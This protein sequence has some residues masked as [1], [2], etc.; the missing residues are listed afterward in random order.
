MRPRVVFE[1]FDMNESIR[2]Y[3]SRDTTLSILDFQVQ[4]IFRFLILT[5]QFSMMEMFEDLYDHIKGYVW[6]CWNRRPHSPVHNSEC[7]DVFNNL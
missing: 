2:L 7:C 5:L 6:D 3:S 4:R 1:T